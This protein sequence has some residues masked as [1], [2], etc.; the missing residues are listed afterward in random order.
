MNIIIIFVII[1]VIIIIIIIKVE[2]GNRKKKHQMVESQIIIGDYMAA[3][4]TFAP[5]A[6]E[7]LPRPCGKDPYH[8]PLYHRASFLFKPDQQQ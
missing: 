6:P 8:A 3:P 7:E 2:I 5:R 4:S 1:F